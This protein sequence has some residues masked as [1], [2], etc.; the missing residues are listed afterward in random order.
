[1]ESMI[2]LFI[3]NLKEELMCFQKSNKGSVLGSLDEDSQNKQ[4]LL[5]NDILK[6]EKLLDQVLKNLDDCTPQVPQSEHNLDQQKNDYRDKLI[7]KI[8]DLEKEIILFEREIKGFEN[9][10]NR[11]QELIRDVEERILSNRNRYEELK[12]QLYIPFYG[13]NVK[14][15]MDK[16]EKK[17]IPALYH[18]RNQCIEHL[19][20]LLHKRKDYEQHHRPNYA[21]LEELKR[22][23]KTFEKETKNEDQI[24]NSI[25]EQVTQILNEIAYLFILKEHLEDAIATNISIDKLITFLDKNPKLIH[26]ENDEIYLKILDKWNNSHDI[27]VFRNNILEL[28]TKIFN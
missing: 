7:M 12:L 3:D 6:L 18:D 19:N 1:M 9:E 25:H 22:K 21:L 27:S 17:I 14:F 16:I 2:Q 8:N 4:Q 5:Q 15:D 26:N 10:Q 11:I 20:K 24:I 28:K 13:M 23:L